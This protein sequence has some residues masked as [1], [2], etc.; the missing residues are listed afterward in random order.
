MTLTIAKASELD[1]KR[2][3]ELTV[4]THQ[5]NSTGVTYSYEQ[6][7]DLIESNDHEVLIVQLDDKYGTYGKIGLVLIKKETL[8]WELKLLLMSCRVMSRGIGGVLLSYLVNQAKKNNV[9]LFAR[10]VPND[11]N[12][13]MYMTY[14]FGGFQE[15]ENKDDF[16]MLKANT[17]E[18]REMP[19]YLVLAEG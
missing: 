15:I 4:R 12:R 1:L 6:L 18:M 5:L 14:K 2:A 16:I 9:E 10:F 11:R 7:K 3:E 8:R 13:I 19:N 17:H